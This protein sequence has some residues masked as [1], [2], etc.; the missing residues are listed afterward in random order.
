MTTTGNTKQGLRKKD[1][2]KVHQHQ[3]I[4]N[5]NCTVQGTFKCGDEMRR[6]NILADETAQFF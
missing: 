2:G 3:K 4:Q 1:E 5:K 6:H